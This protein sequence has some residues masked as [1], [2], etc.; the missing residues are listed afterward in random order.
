MDKA[1]VR[2]QR[3][4]SSIWIIPGLALLLGAWMLLNAVVNADPVVE[5]RFDTADGIEAGRT[6]VKTRSIEIGLVENV[7]LSDDNKSVVVSLRIKRTAASL[8]REDSRFWVARPRIGLGGISGMGTILSGAYIVLQPGESD[9]GWS[10]FVGLEAP[11]ATPPSAKGLRISL[12]SED[13]GAINCGDPIL[14]R[15]RRVG[16]VDA[17][18][19]EFENNRFRYEVFVEAPFDALVTSPTRFWKAS[20]V[21]LKADSDGISINADSMESILAGGVAFDLPEGRVAGA[22]VSDGDSFWLYES[23]DDIDR[24]PYRHYAQYLLF[25]N[26]SVRGLKVGAPVEY[27]GIQ[28]GHVEDVSFSYLRGTNFFGTEEVPVP[29]LIRIFPGHFQLDDS[30]EGLAQMKELVEQHIDSGLRA[31]LQRGSLLTGNLFVGL[32]FYE[33]GDDV[34]ADSG[35]DWEYEVFPTQSVGLEQIE[36]RIVGILNTVDSLPLKALTVEVREAIAHA[37]EMFDNSRGLIGNLDTLLSSEGALTLPHSFRKTLDAVE[38]AVSG[39]SPDS[40]MY[41]ELEASFRSLNAALSDLQ[42]LAQ[43]LERQ[44]NAILF[45]KPSKPDPEPKAA[46]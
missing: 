46:K 39:L 34:H 24:F 17:T 43:K 4:I 3:R 35:V 25:F 8:L 16:Q 1:E 33:Q 32:D 44:P 18:E 38:S 29:A 22:E 5:I 42:R 41:G 12:F 15:G 36:R 30:P 19:F 9:E 31:A 7:R 21:E 6:K 23:K 10:E 45:S 13:S 2:K 11:P 40:Q 26:D 27:R 20:A 14:Y 37:R 28:V